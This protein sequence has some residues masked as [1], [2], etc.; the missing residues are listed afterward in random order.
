M[1]CNAMKR[2]SGDLYEDVSIGEQKFRGSFL[3]VNRSLCGM[4]G[5]TVRELTPLRINDVDWGH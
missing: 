3:D 4:T 2:E 1:G 5:H